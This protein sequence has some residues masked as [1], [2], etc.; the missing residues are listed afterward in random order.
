V[1]IQQHPG[2]NLPDTPE[3]NHLDVGSL[4]Q[5]SAFQRPGTTLAGQHY[6]RLLNA[7]RIIQAR[8][9]PDGR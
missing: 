8:T 6:V 4:S 2:V 7:E 1:E 3:A 9:P 5:E